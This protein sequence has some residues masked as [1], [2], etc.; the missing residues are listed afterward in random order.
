M[1]SGGRD[2]ADRAGAADLANAAESLAGPIWMVD[3]LGHLMLQ[4]PAH[5]DPV[6]VRKD[7]SK[8]IYNSRIG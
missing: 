3:P 2:S 1:P 7:V 5:A 4:F 6:Q 8:L